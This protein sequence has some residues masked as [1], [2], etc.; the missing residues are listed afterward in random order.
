MN[1]L[2]AADRIQR[3]VEELAAQ[4]RAQPHGTFKLLFNSLHVAGAE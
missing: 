2:L 3:R 4:N 1:V